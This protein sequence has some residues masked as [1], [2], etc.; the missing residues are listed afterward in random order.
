MVIEEIKTTRTR[1]SVIIDGR[2]WFEI[3]DETGESTKEE[4][5][6]MLKK[7]VFKKLAIHI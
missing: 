6:E 4:L 3:H 2:E 5:I 7:A 1:A